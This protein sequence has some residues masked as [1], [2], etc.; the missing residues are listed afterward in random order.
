M[1]P[2]LLMLPRRPASAY[3]AVAGLSLAAHAPCDV[4]VTLCK[5]T[6]LRL[7]VERSETPDQAQAIARSVR[8]SLYG[9]SHACRSTTDDRSSVSP[10]ARSSTHLGRLYDAASVVLVMVWDAVLVRD[11]HLAAVALRNAHAVVAAV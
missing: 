5:T 8:E 9:A 10:A 6:L 1:H 3:V 7:R 4:L 11:A 2:S